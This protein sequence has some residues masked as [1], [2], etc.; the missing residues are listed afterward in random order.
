MDDFMHLDHEFG[1]R[2]DHEFFLKA[3]CFCIKT[4]IKLA[5]NPTIIHLVYKQKQPIFGWLFLLYLGLVTMPAL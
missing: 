2:L 3:Q 4:L 1:S 5:G